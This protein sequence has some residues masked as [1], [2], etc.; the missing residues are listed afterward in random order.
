MIELV[1]KG[2]FQAIRECE[3]ERGK[4]EEKK[5]K[6]KKKKLKS[7]CGES[8]VPEV[9]VES[10]VESKPAPKKIKIRVKK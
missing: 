6:I 5:V 7:G 10:G 4:L 3:K 2:I 1:G 8:K 9:K